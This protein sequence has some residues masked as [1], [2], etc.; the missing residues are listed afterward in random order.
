M[1]L[2]RSH[3]GTC[4]SGTPTG[5]R[6]F[7][8]WPVTWNAL[9]RGQI[10]GE[11]NYRSSTA[12]AAVL[13]QILLVSRRGCITLQ[14]WPDVVKCLKC[15]R[16]ETRLGFSGVLHTDEVTGSNPVSPTLPKALQPKRLTL[17]P[18]CAGCGFQMTDTAES[19]RRIH[20]G[21]SARGPQSQCRSILHSAHQVRSRSPSVVRFRWSATGKTPSRPVRVCRIACRESPARNGTRG[22]PNSPTR[23]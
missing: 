14:C 17:T 8:G 7:D 21:G 9:G 23:C 22:I 4:Q 11:A 19:F 1:T 2:Y 12:I 13:P 6:C 3:D 16:F 10:V 20:S 15:R 18:A 5:G